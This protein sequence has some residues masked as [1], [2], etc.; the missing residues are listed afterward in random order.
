MSLLGKI[1]VTLEDPDLVVE[2]QP[3]WGTLLKM[4]RNFKLES[5]IEAMSTPSVTHLSWLAW[6]SWSHKS[7]VILEG[8]GERPTLAAFEERLADIDLGDSETPLEP[9]NDQPSTTL[10]SSP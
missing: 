3:N 5:G 10:P 2:V 7:A 6:Q 4:E 9:T 1:R 8:D